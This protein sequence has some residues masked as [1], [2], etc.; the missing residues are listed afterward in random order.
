MVHIS[1]VPDFKLVVAPPGGGCQH[2]LIGGHYG[3]LK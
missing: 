2:N 1:F 3:L